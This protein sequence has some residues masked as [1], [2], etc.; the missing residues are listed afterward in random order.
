MIGPRIAIDNNVV[1]IWST[2]CVV[3]A[4]QGL[5]EFL[6]HHRGVL[7]PERHSQELV[8]LAV[9]DKGR[10]AYVRVCHP[11]LV[12][13]FGK[14]ELR[15]EGRLTHPFQDLLD[16]GHVERVLSRNTVYLFEI[17]AQPGCAIGL[18]D[19]YY[20]GRPRASGR[21]NVPL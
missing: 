4:E 8:F 9:M 21:P 18:P 20:R 19:C 6:E 15:D 3:N 10:F 12:I 11:N 16:P 5:H 14:V 2:K 7:Y 13:T 1:H 17:D